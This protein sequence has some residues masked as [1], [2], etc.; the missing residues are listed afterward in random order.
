MSNIDSSFYQR[1]GLVKDSNRTYVP[2]LYR[3]CAEELRAEEQESAPKASRTCILQ[4]RPIIGVLFSVSAGSDGELFPLYI[5]RNL[6][7][8]DENC[9]VCLRESTVSS[10]HATVLARRQFDENGEEVVIVAITDNSSTCGTKLNGV[11]VDY[12][13]VFCHN[14]DIITV[15]ENYQLLLTL[16][17]ARDRLQVSPHFERIPDEVPAPPA[18]ETAV[19]KETEVSDSSATVASNHTENTTMSI[20]PD[21][22]EFYRPSSNKSTDHYN[23]K[24]IIV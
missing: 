18:T 12:D 10:S 16:F 21:N 23:N 2:D 19:Q 6:V 3:Q 14:G 20:E 22:A 13:K 17:D 1:S 24:T 11:D 5:G 9:D 15:G 7:G 8:R 4:P